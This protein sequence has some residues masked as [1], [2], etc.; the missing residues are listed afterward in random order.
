MQEGMDRVSQV[1]DNCDIT[2]CMYPTMVYE[3]TSSLGIMDILRNSCI[4]FVTKT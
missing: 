2:C 4:I 1:C 3:V